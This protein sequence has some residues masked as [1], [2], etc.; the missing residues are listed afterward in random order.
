MGQFAPHH[1]WP[2]SAP[3]AHQ[4]ARTLI[5]RRED[6]SSQ[7]V[8]RWLTRRGLVPVVAGTLFFAAANALA[9]FTLEL[10]IKRLA[11]D[12]GA[13]A[14]PDSARLD[15]GP[16]ARPDA[17]PDVRRPGPQSAPRTP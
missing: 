15:A 8:R 3:G 16:P 12:A 2:P 9:S 17:M 10:T 11:L 13:D 6:M 7:T 5:A 1:G 14:A 4:R